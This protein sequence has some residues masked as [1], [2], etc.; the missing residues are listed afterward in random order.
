MGG[1]LKKIIDFEDIANQMLIHGYKFPQKIFIRIE[2]P[3]DV[4]K[5]ALGYFVGPGF[6]W[7]PEYENVADWLRDNEGRGLYLFGA[8]GRGKTV[9]AKMILP[10]ILLKYYR[11]VATVLDAQE[12]NKKL[13][14]ILKKRVLVLD[15]IGTEDVRVAY[16]E[17]RWAFPEIMDKAEKMGNLVIITSNLDARAIEAKY[18]IR[19]IE[20]IKATCKRIVFDGESLRK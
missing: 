18:G 16:G 4:L 20:R 3:K 19:T 9:L 7:L 10:A 8:N 11:R 14:E 13:D 5:A 6:K 1:V 2:N 12:M 15:D 17:R